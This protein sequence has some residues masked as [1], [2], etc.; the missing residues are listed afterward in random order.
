VACDTMLKTSVV[1]LYRRRE[2][3]LQPPDGGTTSWIVSLLGLA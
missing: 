1:G 2:R 3:R